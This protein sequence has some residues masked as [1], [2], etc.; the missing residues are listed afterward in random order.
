MLNSIQ[1]QIQIITI[2]FKAL[3]FYNDRYSLPSFFLWKKN[4]V[5]FLTA[6]TAIP[7][8]LFTSLKTVYAI[9]IFFFIF[10]FAIPVVIIAVCFGLT[11]R[12]AATKRNAT[13]LSPTGRR[14][15]ARKT[16][17]LALIGGVT[18]SFFICWGYWHGYYLAIWPYFFNGQFYRANVVLHIVLNML[19]DILV[20]FNA[21]LNPFL[22]ALNRAYMKRHLVSFFTCGRKGTQ[23]ADMGNGRPDGM[24]S[25]ESDSV[26][27]SGD[28]VTFNVA[29]EAVAEKVP[30]S[31]ASN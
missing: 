10:T 20:L 11:V 9:H 19:T 31:P 22:Y 3:S 6:C 12:A 15:L 8:D 28:G 26:T 13:T 4:P 2:T 29:D 17:F 16:R 7:V 25:T 27:P 23:A 21:A 18:L 5:G 24:E 1:I 30:N 14:S